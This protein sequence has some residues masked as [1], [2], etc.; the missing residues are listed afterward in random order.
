MIGKIVAVLLVLAGLGWAALAA[1]G[2]MAD[3]T[4]GSF[5]HFIGMAWWAAIPLALGVALWIWG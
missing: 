2:E 4:G 5:G 3:P 1:A